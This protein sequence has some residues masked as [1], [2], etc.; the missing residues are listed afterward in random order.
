MSNGTA[1][2]YFDVIGGGHRRASGKLCERHRCILQKHKR[3]AVW[4]LERDLCDRLSQQRVQVRIVAADG[5]AL[6]AKASCWFADLGLDAQQRLDDAFLRALAALSARNDEA[7]RRDE[8]AALALRHTPA[9]FEL[10]RSSWVRRMGVGVRPAL[11]SAFGAFP[12]EDAVVT[13]AALVQAERLLSMNGPR[14]A[15]GDRRAAPSQC[16]ARAGHLRSRRAQ[17]SSARLSRARAR[18]EAARARG[19]RRRRAADEKQRQ[20]DLFVDVPPIVRRRAPAE[21]IVSY[22]VPYGVELWLVRWRVDTSGEARERWVEWGDLP[23]EELQDRAQE[24]KEDIINLLSGLVGMEAAR[25]RESYVYL[26]PWEVSSW[27]QRG[28]VRPSAPPSVEPL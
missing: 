16:S 2:E 24:K 20:R 8:L 21:S 11:I 3:A 12:W 7:I 13:G 26:D 27:W 17:Q 23:T 6:R 18:A 22:C 1:E 4:S 25:A 19:T 28:A 9:D 14:D 5:C 10:S 15:R